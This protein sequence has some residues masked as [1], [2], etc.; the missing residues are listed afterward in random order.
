MVTVAV[1]PTSEV[2]LSKYPSFS[3]HIHGSV[4]GEH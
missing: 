4:L 1:Q 3:G 2:T